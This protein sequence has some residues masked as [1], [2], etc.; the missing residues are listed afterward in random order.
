MG[1]L[2]HRGL[3]FFLPLLIQHGK[4]L[5]FFK[6]KRGDKCRLESFQVIDAENNRKSSRD[7]IIAV[8][9]VGSQQRM[10]LSSDN[11]WCRR[12]RTI[13]NTKLRPGYAPPDGAV[14]DP[15][16]R[17]TKTYSIAASR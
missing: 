8:S 3:Y 15:K 10:N 5:K 9:R 1:Y 4:L 11:L 6:L 17:I 2:F 14:R 7:F 12:W 16:Y 13:L